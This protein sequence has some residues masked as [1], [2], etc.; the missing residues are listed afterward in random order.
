MAEVISRT[1]LQDHTGAA[2]DC[3]VMLHGTPLQPGAL[4]AAQG[5]TDNDV[6]DMQLRLRCVS[7]EPM[8]YH[9]STTATQGWHHDQGQDAHRQ[10]D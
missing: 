2:M 1:L 5:V 8:V 9:L 7:P 3:M 10:G 6:L 4:L